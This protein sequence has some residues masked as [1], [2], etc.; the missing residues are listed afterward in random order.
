MAGIRIFGLERTTEL[1]AV[2]ASNSGPRIAI[3][4]AVKQNWVKPLTD[5]SGDRW[6]HAFFVI[7]DGSDEPNTV[8]VSRPGCFSRPLATVVAASDAVGI[9]V[10]Q[11]CCTCVGRLISW[12]RRKLDEPGVTYSFLTMAIAG[13]SSLARSYAPGGLE[14]AVLGAIARSA[15][16]GRDL[17]GS[18]CSAFV[19]DGLSELC[20]RC[21]PPSSWPIRQRTPPWRT[22]P[23]RIDSALPDALYTG[24]RRIIEPAAIR[25]LITPAD[26]WSMDYYSERF[27][28][29]R[30]PAARAIG[31]S[32]AP[33]PVLPGRPRQDSPAAA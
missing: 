17:A 2:G 30:E 1:T 15:R 26:L 19:W 32:S 6:A 7:W 23:G 24:A 20:A 16:A 25:R 29:Q 33:N 18:T 8:E 3:G 13:F 11:L 10:P 31:A 9:A 28:L 21:R 22:R 14:P 5:V 4:V 27:H 12:A